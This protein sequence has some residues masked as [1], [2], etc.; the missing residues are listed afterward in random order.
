MGLKDLFSGFTSRSS[1]KTVA[2]Q[3]TRLTNQN[4]QHE[5]RL[6][7]A[8]LLSEANTEDAIYGMLR[9]Y[10]M[11]LEKSYMDQEEK[12]YVKELILTKGQ[13]AVAPILRFLKVT[14]N[15]NWPERIM[16]NI[17][18]DD[19]EVVG[20]L[21]KVI[22]DERDSGDMKGQKRAKL[23]SLLIKYEDPRIPALVASF[24]KDFDEGVRFTS[25]EILDRQGDDSVRDA[26]LEVMAGEEEE[27]VRVRMRVLE[28]FLRNQWRVDPWKEKVGAWLPPEYKV[29][30]NIIVDAL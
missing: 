15:V 2:K 9:R 4:V 11:T 6:R 27:S 18:N 3:V 16:S 5:D 17:I 28:T 20:H 7:A 23:L 10:D 1:E 19:A 14:D 25:V 24:L 21:L 26:L 12:N 8:E 13:D 30:D 22:E 29:R